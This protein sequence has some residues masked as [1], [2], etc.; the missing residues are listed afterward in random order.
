MATDAAPISAEA[1]PEKAEMQSEEETLGA[2]AQ[3]PPAPA[4]APAAA[5]PPKTPKKTPRTPRQP[6]F[7]NL[8]PALRKQ[9]RR[10]ASPSSARPRANHGLSAEAAEEIAA[11]RALR[12]KV[13]EF[14]SKGAHGYSA[15]ILSFCRAINMSNCSLIDDD[16]EALASVLTPSMRNIRELDLSGNKFSDRTFVALSTALAKGSAPAITHLQL[17]H[18]NI[19]D[20]GV[21]A[22]AAALTAF[23]GFDNLRRE[24]IKP[25]ETTVRALPRLERLSLSHN[26]IGAKGA[27]Q[28]ARAAEDG[29]LKEL[30]SLVLS[31]NPIGDRGLGA[32]AEVTRDDEVLP[33]LTELHICDT[34][35]TDKGLTALAETMMPTVGGLPSL[36]LLLVDDQHVEHAK[37]RTARDARTGQ[38]GVHATKIQHWGSEWEQSSSPRR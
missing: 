9:L 32:F 22:F 37:L 20:A 16:G 2:P 30:A 1:A 17:R 34:E 28:L 8:P 6:S 21:K 15:S 4:D 25:H 26:A 10:H 5:S 12:K 31:S 33:K 35:I 24:L 14:W 18:N 29:A 27:E 3:A 23:D 11:K 36:R 7:S 19:S 13:L 38:G